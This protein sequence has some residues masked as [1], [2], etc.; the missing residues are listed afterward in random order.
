MKD[1][2]DF[3]RVSSSGEV[4]EAMTNATRESLAAFAE[5]GA[6]PEEKLIS[7]IVSA[8]YSNTVRLLGLYHAWL[9]EKG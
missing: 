3:L 2:D 6:I 8:S 7:A 1:F 4:Q 9:S 5:D